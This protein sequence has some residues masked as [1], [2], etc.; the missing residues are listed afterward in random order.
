MWLTLFL[1]LQL[2]GSIVVRE[3]WHV[4]LVV[5]R[6]ELA[7]TFDVG[8]EV[9]AGVGASEEASGLVVALGG[10]LCSLEGTQPHHDLL[11]GVLDL[12]HPPY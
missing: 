5:A 8:D 9:C 2:S 11:R 3:G 4:K 10:S 7:V 6:E 1:L 12:H